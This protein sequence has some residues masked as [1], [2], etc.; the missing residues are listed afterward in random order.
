MPRSEGASLLTTRAWMRE[1]AGRLRR[2]FDGRLS[3]APRPPER[4]IVA[5]PDPVPGRAELATEMYGGTFRLAEI[6]VETYGESPFTIRDAPEL[7]AEAL[8]GFGWMRHHRAAGTDLAHLHVRTLLDDWIKAHG[9]PARELP[10]RP[11]IAAT[12]LRHWISHSPVVLGHSD[13]AFLDEFLRQLAVHHRFVR[14]AARDSI[15]PFERMRLLVTLCTVSLAFPSTRQEQ[16]RY[17]T[18]LANELDVQILPDGGHISRRA[19]ALTDLAGDLLPLAECYE[20]LGLVMPPAIIRALDRLLP[21][22]ALHR[23]TDGTLARHNGTRGGRVKRTNAILALNPS[24]G[25]PPTEAP[26]SGYQRL[27]IGDT[28]VVVDTGV[29]PPIAHASRAHAGTLSFEMSVGRGEDATPLVVNLG[30]VSRSRPKLR[31]AVRTVGAHSTLTIDGAADPWE[32]V[33]TGTRGRLFNEPLMGG[34]STVEL[35]RAD[36]QDG[37][38]RG[39]RASH[40]AFAHGAEPRTVHARTFALSH[41]GTKLAGR[42]E[43]TAP[44]DRTG[45]WTAPAATVRFHLHPSVTVT[46][47]AS[48][49]SRVTLRPERG[50]P[51]VLEVEGGEARV[52]DSVY[53]VS[54]QPEETQ[55]VVLSIPAG[56]GAA[57]WTFIRQ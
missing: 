20:A 15:D 1:T 17:A 41:E 38:W 36:A 27:A 42:D 43:L 33:T 3:L 39:F 16:R 11:I 45:D 14:R 32:I 48:Q 9:E 4:I 55:Q 51:W 44:P 6:R 21:A 37:S 12:R 46:M 49:T 22:L 53:I 56:A 30:E 19:A 5:P 29:T 24:R 50:K 54:G 7:W 18:A 57:N 13:F 47:D 10:W 40:D 28:V 2:L 31:R 23:H 34:P 25:A 52:E 35:R 8:H 26:Q